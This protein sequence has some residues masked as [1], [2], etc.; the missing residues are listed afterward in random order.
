MAYAADHRSL[1]TAP[2]SLIPCPSF[3]N[4]CY[5]KPA[6]VGWSVA[7]ANQVA[8]VKCKIFKN[9]ARLGTE[10]KTVC[11]VCAQR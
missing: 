8:C 2:L 5:L 7:Q 10:G 11:Q 1:R 9:E 6:N 4:E 3:M